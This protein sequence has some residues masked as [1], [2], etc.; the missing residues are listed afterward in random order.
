MQA[1]LW[2]G[3][4]YEFVRYC[5]RQRFP[6]N[7]KRAICPDRDVRELGMPTTNIGRRNCVT[8]IEPN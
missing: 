4:W 7:G 3:W 8:R 2:L 6:E 5:E 1:I